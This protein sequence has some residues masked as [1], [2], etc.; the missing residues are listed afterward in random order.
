[1]A[2]GSQGSQIG[3][4]K[5]KRANSKQDEPARIVIG[6][7]TQLGPFHDTIPPVHFARNAATTKITTF[8]TDEKFTPA[9]RQDR[10]TGSGKSADKIAL[11]VNASPAKRRGQIKRVSRRMF[12]L[13]Q[14]R[15][16]VNDEVTGD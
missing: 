7:P 13:L 3:L 11:V 10:A 12:Y 14:E 1:M 16:A 2:F 15:N 8:R 4:G 9:R 6:L 5:S